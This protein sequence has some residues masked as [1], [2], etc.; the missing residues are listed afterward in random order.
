MVPAILTK[1]KNRINV[2]DFIERGIR[3]YDLGSVGS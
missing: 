3:Q 1:Q 2:F